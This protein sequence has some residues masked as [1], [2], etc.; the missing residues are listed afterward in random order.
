MA[1]SEQ[2]PNGV[3]GPDRVPRG[4][5]VGEPSTGAGAVLSDLDRL[6]ALRDREG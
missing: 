4:I 5:D 6:A 2:V 1:H 3:P